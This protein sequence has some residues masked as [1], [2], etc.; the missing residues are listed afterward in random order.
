MRKARAIQVILAAQMALET[1]RD[2]VQVAWERPVLEAEELPGWREM[3]CQGPVHMLS[4]QPGGR[5]DNSSISILWRSGGD[6]QR[7]GEEGVSLWVL[8]GEGHP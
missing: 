8:R 5:E 3:P 4:P 6:R 7:D 2:P 1:K